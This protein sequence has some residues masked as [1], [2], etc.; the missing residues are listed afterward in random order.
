MKRLF[1]ST[2]IIGALVLSLS[3]CSNISQPTISEEKIENCYY[4][5]FNDGE[6]LFNYY[7]YGVVDKETI[8]RYFNGET[9]PITIKSPFCD[10]DYSYTF[11][12][13]DVYKLHVISEEEVIEYEI[14]HRKN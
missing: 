11:S 8:D 5:R 12:S 2:L 7:Y 13:D 4:V 1:I 14:K 6:G 3:G 9:V 10:R